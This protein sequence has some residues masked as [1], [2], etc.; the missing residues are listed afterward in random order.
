MWLLGCGGGDE[1]PVHFIRGEQQS[2][3]KI[4][5]GLRAGRWQGD[6]AKEDNDDNI[7]VSA[8]SAGDCAMPFLLAHIKMWSE[9]S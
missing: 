3:Q 2:C 4:R 6:I 7:S 8:R 9:S 5:Q 1:Q